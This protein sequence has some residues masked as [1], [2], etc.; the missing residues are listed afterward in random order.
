MKIQASARLTA[1]PVEAKSVKEAEKALKSIASVFGKPTRKR[2]YPGGEGSGEV[3]WKSKDCRLVIELDV[4]YHLKVSVS[5]PG[6][7]VLVAESS[8]DTW[9]AVKRDLQK[10]VKSLGKAVDSA[11]ARTQAKFEQLN[12]KIGQLK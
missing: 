12:E 10:K 6:N 4:D 2:E 7:R 8:G 1:S 5:V 11:G 3:E 9:N